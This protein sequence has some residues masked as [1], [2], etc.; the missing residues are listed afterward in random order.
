VYT[1]LHICFAPSD[2]KRYFLAHDRCST[3]ARSV[4]GVDGA[5]GLP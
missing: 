1:L 4:A 2:S 5:G 3:N